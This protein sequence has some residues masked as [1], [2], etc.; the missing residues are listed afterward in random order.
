MNFIENILYYSEQCPDKPAIIDRNGQR[1]TTYSQLVNKARRMANY[2]KGLNLTRHS[3]ILFQLPTSMECL[4]T[5]LGIWMNN[6]VAVPVGIFFP[7][8]RVDYIRSHCESPLVITPDIFAKAMEQEADVF[9]MNQQA[10]NE[11]LLIYTSGS[12]GKPKGIIH[13][14]KFINTRCTHSAKYLEVTENTIM[15]VGAPF[16]FYCESDVSFVSD[17]AWYG[18]HHQ[19]WGDEG[20]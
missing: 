20:C 19:S 6:H 9:Q 15:G 5:E 8:Q 12:T 13:D 3:F 17:R 11:A 10:D 18:S 14:F 2:I 7:K 16:L 1:V 4:V